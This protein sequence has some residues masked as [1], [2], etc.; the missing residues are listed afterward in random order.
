MDD[1]RGRGKD[2]H[3][4]RAIDPGKRKII[5]QPTAVDS[6]SLGPFLPP[7]PVGL[8]RALFLLR[9]TKLRVLTDELKVLLLAVIVGLEIIIPIRGQ[10]QLVTCVVLVVGGIREPDYPGISCNV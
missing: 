4:T 6:A 1:D 2:Q 9:Q 8:F 3:Q 5:V 7:E 10:S